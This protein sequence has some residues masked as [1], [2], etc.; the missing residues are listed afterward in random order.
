MLKTTT[1]TLA[2]ILKTDYSADVAVAGVCT[3]SRK[4]MDG[5]LFLALVGDNFDAHDYINE[6]EKNGAA[7][8]VVSK[9]VA[10]KLPTLLVQNTQNALVEISKYH[11]QNINPKVV[12]ITGSNGKTTTKNMLKNIL[13]LKAPTLATRGNLNNHLGVPLTLLELQKKHRFAV[14]EMGANHLGE[15]AYLRAIAVPAVAVVVNAM[16]AH[17]GEFGGFANLIKA[18]GEIYAPNSINIV[19]TITE[20][21]GD[22]SFGSGGDIFASNVDNNK[23][24]LNIGAEK[25]KVTLQLLGRHNID[26][27]LAASACAYA[28]GVDIRTISQ[29]LQNTSAE[30]GRLNLVRKNNLTIIDDSYNASPSSMQAAIATLQNFQGE[31]IAV[32]GDMAELG[33][34]SKKFHQQIGKLAQNATDKLYTY[35]ELAQHYGGIH[36]DDLAQLSAQ[37]LSKNQGSTILIKGSRMAKLDELARLLQK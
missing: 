37:I 2:Q 6:A 1:K 19:N 21:E 28:L 24:T 33:A 15:I 31:K 27:A 26:N 7:A 8:L 14:I 5:A 32:L 34:D 18:K 22:I 36:F 4:P 29:G 13:N 3:D 25:I 20:F 35:G 23:F 30:P 17:I 16:D 9:K 11:L 10:S 12:A